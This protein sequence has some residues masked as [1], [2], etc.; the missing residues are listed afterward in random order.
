MVLS[1]VEAIAATLYIVGL[2]EEALQVIREFKW[3][4]EFIKINQE[5]LDMYAEAADSEEVVAAQKRYLEAAQAEYSDR[6]SRAYGP[7]VFFVW[8]ARNC[9]D[10]LV[11][12]V[13]WCV[14]WQ[15]CRRRLR[16]TTTATRTR[17]T[18]AQRVPVIAM[19]TLSLLEQ[20]QVQVQVQPQVQVLIRRGPLPQLHLEP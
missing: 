2:K 7:S 13:M 1:C 15:A 12:T 10:G 17:T 11:L 18:T 3:G 5:P 20:A 19:T 4:D 6:A 16:M 8:A 14:V 9:V